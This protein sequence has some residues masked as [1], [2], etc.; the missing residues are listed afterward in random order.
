MTITTYSNASE[1]HVLDKS[2]TKINENVSVILK[3]DTDIINPIIII[4][5]SISHN[6]NYIYISEFNR[7]YYVR[8]ITHSQ[9]RYYIECEVDVLMSFNADIKDLEVIANRSSSTYNVYQKD[10]SIPFENRNVISTQPFASG[11][12]GDTLILAVNG[13]GAAPTP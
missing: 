3:D 12:V 9:Q 13:G 1:E 7:Y 10:D 2:I 11:F 6:F 8:N 4:S 5:N